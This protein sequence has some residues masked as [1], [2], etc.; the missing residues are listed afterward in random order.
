MDFVSVFP[1]LRTIPPQLPGCRRSPVLTFVG[2]P[3]PPVAPHSARDRRAVVWVYVVVAHPGEVLP[4][5]GKV[6][7]R[8]LSEVTFVPHSAAAPVMFPYEARGTR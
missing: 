3:G 1:Y 7:G 8:D 4:A 5:C 2:V 6:P